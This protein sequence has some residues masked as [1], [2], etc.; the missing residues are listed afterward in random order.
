[1]FNRN[2]PAVPQ[3]LREGLNALLNNT[4]ASE[5]IKDY[6]DK[7]AGR[8]GERNGGINTFYGRLI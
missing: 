3:N 5:I 8:I 4:N 2:N 6:I 1:L 7:Y